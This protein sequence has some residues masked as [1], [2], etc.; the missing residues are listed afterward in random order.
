MDPKIKRMLYIATHFEN[1]YA[2]KYEATKA[3]R[4]YA[5]ENREYYD[6][7]IDKV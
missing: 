7:I 1:T 4:R 2:E 5:L 6:K 3:C